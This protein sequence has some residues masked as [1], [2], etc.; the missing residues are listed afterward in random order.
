MIN[1]II[2]SL[3]DE[4]GN[5]LRPWAEAGFVGVAYD[6]INDC[7]KETLITM[8]QSITSTKTYQASERCA[9]YSPTC[10]H[11]L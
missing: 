6:I 1:D 9:Q 8:E 11:H 3:F 4:S 5:A 7:K 2:L 10:D